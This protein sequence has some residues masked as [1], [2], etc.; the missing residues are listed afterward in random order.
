MLLNVEPE[1][2]IILFFIFIPEATKCRAS[3]LA[4]KFSTALIVAPLSDL[5]CN[6]H[7]LDVEDVLVESL[8]DNVWGYHCL[9]ELNHQFALLRYRTY[10]ERWFWYFL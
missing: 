3:S 7:H 8:I 9:A 2:L 6:C 5:S 4:L 1:V 10:L